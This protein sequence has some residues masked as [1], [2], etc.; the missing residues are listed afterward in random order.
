MIDL[1]IRDRVERMFVDGL[2]ECIEELPV[3]PRRIDESVDDEDY[4]IV[5]RCEEA[6]ETTTGSGVYYGDC[7]IVFASHVSDV[8]SDQHGKWLKKIEDRLVEMNLE[9]ITDEKNGVVGFGWGPMVLREAS[10]FK[11]HG[12]VVTFRGGFGYL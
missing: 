8:G 5:C 10:Q 4:W 9:K 3:F 7:S 6:E 11:T 1:P 12:D 2:K